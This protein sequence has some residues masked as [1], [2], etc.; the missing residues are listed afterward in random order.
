MIFFT[1]VLD[2]L[3]NEAVVNYISLR[4]H[5][6]PGQ[7]LRIHRKRTGIPFSMAIKKAP[8]LPDAFKTNFSCPQ[9]ALKRKGS[10]NRRQ[11]S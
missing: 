6:L 11:G 10:Y 2:E 3:L 5:E 7:R 8:G 9:A 1:P 4:S